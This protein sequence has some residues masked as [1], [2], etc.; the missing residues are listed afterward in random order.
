MSL[1]PPVSV[2][3]A[4]GGTIPGRQRTAVIL[5]TGVKRCGT[6]RYWLPLSE[7]GKANDRPDG[8]RSRCHECV[9]AYYREWRA[10]P[11]NAGKIAAYTRAC[12]DRD[13]KRDQENRLRARCKAYG[14]TVEQYRAMLAAQD[15]RCGMC[16]LP[17]EENGIMLAIDHDHACCPDPCR[18]CGRCLRG[19]LCD[20]CNRALGY[21][22]GYRERAD[23]YLRKGKNPVGKG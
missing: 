16:N 9:S 2:I 10:R 7:F 14:I 5:A 22:E 18:S 12:R 6:C 1:T 8:V 19:L 17:E 4:Y 11:E 20:P 15:G 13:P 23:R 3:T 21:V